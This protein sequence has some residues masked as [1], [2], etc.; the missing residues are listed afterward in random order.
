M[1]NRTFTSL[2][3]SGVK[4]RFFE[5]SVRS[6]ATF[7]AFH[8]FKISNAFSTFISQNHA[9]NSKLLVSG[10]SFSRFLDHAVAV[11]READIHNAMQTEHKSVSG[12]NGEVL[13]LDSS[14]S[15]CMT[16]ESHGGALFFDAKTLSVK[17]DRVFFLK[18]LTSGSGGAFYATLDNM[19]VTRACFDECHAYE[20][21][22][23]FYIDLNSK[24]FTA[25]FSEV[26]IL[27][28]S[29]S[30]AF[31]GKGAGVFLSGNYLTQLVNCS[32][33]H[34]LSVAA[35]FA[36]LGTN[37]F[38]IMFSEFKNCTSL[39]IFKFIDLNDT[40]FVG[41]S[42]FL[43]NKASNALFHTA[44]KNV[45]I[46][47]VF[48]GN[49]VDSLISGKEIE[50][51]EMSD[52]VTDIKYEF[53][54]IKNLNT[55]N[56]KV[57]KDAESLVVKFAFAGQ[58]RIV[59]DKEQV[60]KNDNAVQQILNQI[61]L[62]KDKVPEYGEYINF[63]PQYPTPRGGE[64]KEEE[65]APIPITRMRHSHNRRSSQALPEDIPNHSSHTRKAKTSS[66][67]H[68]SGQPVPRHPKTGKSQGS[69]QTLHN[70]LTPSASFSPSETFY[71]SRTFLPS[72]QF[73][74]SIPPDGSIVPYVLYSAAGFVV[75][76]VLTSFLF[77]RS[78]DAGYNLITPSE[79]ADSRISDYASSTSTTVT[80]TGE[81]SS[82]VV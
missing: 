6:Q 62:S 41:Y 57:E 2:A 48:I 59:G 20:S 47:S 61:P 80:I 55:P 71:K 53:D 49:E 46:N 50:S 27:R 14:F 1:L 63:A 64:V 13:V 75:F 7:N 22:H 35:A 32:E 44:Q 39:N 66:R 79:S 5:L 40:L 9:A 45:F 26:T 29:I 65:E 60:D 3:L 77:L 28:S 76:A 67:I 4:S 16:Q 56:L 37:S 73:T 81:S 11:N 18:C 78:S 38:Q 8:N 70:V 33:N 17:M 58:C 24:T 19:T 12:G 15:H 10:S 25:N 74:S 31:C 72:L 52:C 54:D 30:D 42:N 23:A 69:K 68:Q 34:A 82:V 21:G 51:L 43:D 36:S